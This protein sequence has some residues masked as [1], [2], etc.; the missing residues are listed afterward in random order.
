MDQK[1]RKALCPNWCPK[2]ITNCQFECYDR[3]E[4]VIQNDQK[5]T[6]LHVHKKDY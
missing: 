3:E 1:L 6:Y 4:N 2:K 5:N